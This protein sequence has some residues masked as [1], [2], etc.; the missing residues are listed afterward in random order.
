MGVRASFLGAICGSMSVKPD[1]N[2]VSY[3]ELKRGDAFMIFASYYHG[4]GANTTK[5]EERLIFSCF[6][7]RG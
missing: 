4:G 5:D 2:L 3:A 1:D 7:T 6:M